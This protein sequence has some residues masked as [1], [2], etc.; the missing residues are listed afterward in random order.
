MKDFKER[1][2][3]EQ[4][5]LAEYCLRFI[6]D[7]VNT[8]VIS[9]TSLLQLYDGFMD[10]ALDSNSSQVNCDISYRIISIL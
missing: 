1:V 2:K 3:A 4:W 6:S 7:L 10:V 5:A 9:N 8:H